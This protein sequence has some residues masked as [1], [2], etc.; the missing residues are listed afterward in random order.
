MVVHC[1]GPFELDL[2]SGRLFRGDRRVPLS[3]P[4]AAILV[5]LVFHAGE[6]VSK[7]A[8]HETAWGAT[9]VQDNSIDKAVSD[10]RKA[11]GETR[12]H[13]T[14]IET[15]RHKGYRFAATVQRTERQPG[16]TP[17]EEQL[18]PYLAF[19]QGRTELDTLDREAIRR[20]GRL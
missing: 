20:A 2:A 5:K 8:L 4:Q 7:D 3:R 16:E 14:Y 17:L 18:A 12:I 19:V 13:R 6:V 15:V 1:F 11:L 9:S 10:I